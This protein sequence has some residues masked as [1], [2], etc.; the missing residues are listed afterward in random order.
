MVMLKAIHYA[1]RMAPYEDETDHAFG[2]GNLAKVLIHA[3]REQKPGLHCDVVCV[4]C[5]YHIR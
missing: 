3:E 4:F 2:V 5:Q 1:E